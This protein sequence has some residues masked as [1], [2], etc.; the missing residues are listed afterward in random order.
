MRYSVVAYRIT[1]NAVFSNDIC[2]LRLI[3][4]RRIGF[5]KVCI[6]K[7]HL[8]SFDTISE[9]IFTRLTKRDCVYISSTLTSVIF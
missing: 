6:L 3:S 4:C 9:M 7:L 8:H 5:E 2:F 1:N